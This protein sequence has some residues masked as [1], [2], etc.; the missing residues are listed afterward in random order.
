MPNPLAFERMRQDDA[1]FLESVLAQDGA[2][3]NPAIF[4]TVG[5]FVLCGVFT[6]ETPMGLSMDLGEH[7]R[8]DDAQ[9]IISQ[10]KEFAYGEIEEDHAEEQERDAM[11]M[12][13]E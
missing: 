2:A 4:V 12:V 5:K 1:D 8:I 9:H 7:T 11:K 10:A 3:L 13:G 6:Y